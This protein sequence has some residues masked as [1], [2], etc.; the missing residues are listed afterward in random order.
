MSVHRSRLGR[1]DLESV[2]PSAAVAALGGGIAAGAVL[3]AT[4]RM[5]SVAGLYGLDG[6]V[7]AWALHLVHS[8]VA[9]ALFA[10]LVVATGRRE[11]L[12]DLAYDLHDPYSG[13]VL[14]LFF[15]LALWAVVVALAVPL[16]LEAVVGSSRP[17]PYTHW[18]SLG[19]LLAF[20][21][22]VGGGYPLVREALESD[23]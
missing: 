2:G 17:L 4:G 8:L 21:G 7:V 5:G 6:V 3:M 13:L 10:G 18:P 1:I 14:G 15:G 23:R 12:A 22:A 11:S 9:G 19:A 20:G 16:W